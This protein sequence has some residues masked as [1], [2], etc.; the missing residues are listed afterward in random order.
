MVSRP[1]DAL[2]PRG[3]RGGCLDLDHQ[4][5]CAHVD[6]QLEG[7]GGDD[8]RQL[9]PLELI[10]D[11]R[12]RLPGD[13]A[14][15]GPSDPFPRQLVQRAREALG[16]APAVGEDH[17]GAMLTD[18]LEQARMDGGPNRGPGGPGRCGAGEDVGILVVLALF[19]PFFGAARAREPRH[20]L[21]GNLDH[22]LEPLFATRIDD[23]H[24]TRHQGAFLVPLR[25]AERPGD[26]VERSLRRRESDALDGVRGRLAI[27]ADS[28]RFESLERN[29]Q[30]R[31]ALGRHHRVDLVDDHRLDGTQELARIGGQQQVERLGRGDENVRR[32]SHLPGALLGGRIP[33]A[34]GDLRD[35]VCD[36]HS[37]G[38]RG[39]P[40]QR[41]PEVAL[42]VHPQGLERRDVQHPTAPFLVGLGREHQT[43]DR[44]QEGREGLA[45]AGRR[46][47]E[48]GLA[49]DDSVPHPLA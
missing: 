35:P 36:A 7:G 19:A 2:D 12:P 26:L 13:G 9:P 38:H 16:Q 18:Q 1:A 32:M 24:G 29:E 45:R 30:M 48:G 27:G 6:P 49:G 22:D 44:R 37:L 11:L 21:D 40:R 17:R 4:V 47:Q 15:M 39:D 34:N 23:G 10:L 31:A 8:R 28:P 25:A 43:I 20:V 42:H 33:A 46:E 41:R 3:H 14:V 5:H